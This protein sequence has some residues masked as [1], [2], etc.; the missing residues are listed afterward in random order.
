MRGF[1]AGLLGASLSYVAIS[2]FRFPRDLQAPSTMM[3]AI[4]IVAFAALACLI[5]PPAQTRFARARPRFS[6]SPP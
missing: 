4:A 1:F 3:F 6:S 5:P 2:L